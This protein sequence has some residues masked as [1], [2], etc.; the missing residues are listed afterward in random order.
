[1]KKIFIFALVI[2]MFSFFIACSPSE[3]VNISDSQIDEEVLSPII[4]SESPTTVINR[5]FSAEP[6][7]YV[8]YVFTAEY[9]NN[10]RTADVDVYQSGSKRFVNY[11]TIVSSQKQTRKYYILNDLYYSCSPVNSEWRCYSTYNDETHKSFSLY[12][13]LDK[14]NFNLADYKITALDSK[15]VAGVTASCYL[16]THKL[17]TREICLYQD[18]L[19]YYA[20]GSSASKVEIIAK[21][22]SPTVSSTVF[23][24]PAQ[25]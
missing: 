10:V 18:M 7:Y 5:F 4:I 19:M 12:A 2:L 6:T 20:D 17:N 9:L 23:T 14:I 8:S 24:L 22:Y 1:M 25:P 11:E 16:L 21:S 3:D 13:D 15:T